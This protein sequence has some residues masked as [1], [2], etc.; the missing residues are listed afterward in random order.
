MP[1]SFS[2][3]VEI[4]GLNC[5][6]LTAADSSGSHETLAGAASKDVN[7]LCLGCCII[8]L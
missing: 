8:L 1:G 6:Q 5:A 3:A 4:Q 7:E 2:R